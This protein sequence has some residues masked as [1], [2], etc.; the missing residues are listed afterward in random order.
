M[1]GTGVIRRQRNPNPLLRHCDRGNAAWLSR[2]SGEYA[3]SPP[4]S[5]AAPSAAIPAAVRMTVFQNR[6][7]Q[8]KTE[9]LVDLDGLCSSVRTTSAASK[10]ELPLLKL[11]TFGDL[12]TKKNSLRSDDNLLLIFG[13]EADYDAERISFADACLILREAGIAALI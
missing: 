6:F 11:A 5:P 1:A 8:T 13:I 4:F 10:R 2:C 3:M 12:R 7:A 9:Q